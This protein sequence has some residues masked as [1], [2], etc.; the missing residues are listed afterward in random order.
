MNQISRDDEIISR[1]DEIDL[2][3]LM[4]TIWDGKWKV[5]GATLIFVLIGLTFVLIKPSS[6]EVSTVIQK[7]KR[8]VFVDFES[9]NGVLKSNN[10]EN[11]Y[12]TDAM[13]IFQ[14][15][16]SEYRD[17]EEILMVLQRDEFVK[18]AIS[19]LDDYDKRVA[20]SKFAKKF[21]LVPPSKASDEWLLS[22]VWHDA[23]AGKILFS[24]ALLITLENVKAAVIANINTLA[25]SIDSRDQR[26]LE[27]LRVELNLLKQKQDARIKKRIHYLM[28]QSAI[29][30]ELGI[31]TNR[32]DANALSQSQTNGV[33]LNIS[34]SDV[35][36]YL[37]GFKAI[38]KEVS[39]I[40]SRS[41]EHQLLVTVDYLE[42]KEKILS[43]ENSLS[44]EQLRNTLKL[45]ENDN[46]ADWVEFNLALADIVSQKNSVLYIVLSAMLGGMIGVIYVLVASATGKR[47][48]PTASA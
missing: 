11:I 20:M 30:K 24:E 3:E 2:L 8:S 32:L 33:S 39:L 25:H 47:N 1:D 42:I 26:Q 16:V 37:R 31:A 6:F 43:L 36:F 27:T 45:I 23:D 22:F 41:E 46:P 44:S 15:F 18:Q 35:P 13:S 34:S 29:A 38:D 9:I 12:Q 19:E 10:L 4:K 40:K 14:M 7:G 17:Y 5:V 48:Q 21:S 28:E